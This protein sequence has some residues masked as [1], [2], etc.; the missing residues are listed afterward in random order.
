MVERSFR[1][2][3]SADY[4]SLIRLTL[5]G[6][7]RRAALLRYDRLRERFEA[8]WPQAEA[9]LRR[10]V[11]AE[12]ATRLGAGG[13]LVPFDPAA[14]L[15]VLG[16]QSGETARALGEAI[17][18][19]VGANLQGWGAEAPFEIWDVVA[20]TDDGLSCRDGGP[21]A[22]VESAGA[23]R[24]LVLGDAEFV[25]H[26]IWDVR[27]GSVFAYRCQPAWTLGNGRGADEEDMAPQ[28]R[29]PARLAALDLE[30]LHKGLEKLEEA[31][32]HDAMAALMLPLHFDTLTSIEAWP[33]YAEGLAKAGPLLL[34]RIRLEV[35]HAPPRLDGNALAAALAPAR[36]FHRNISLR[37]GFDYDGF[38]GAMAAG[39]HSVGVD[40]THDQRDEAALI[41]DMEKF[42]VQAG[43]HAIRTHV[44]GLRSISLG[45]AAVCA[46][47]DL[48][49]SQAIGASLEGWPMD[50]YLL[51]PIDL[52]RRLLSQAGRT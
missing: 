33:R 35:V 37:V 4:W 44:L 24:P 27:R 47:F 7:L 12:A 1:Y 41:E 3:G 21:E 10:V 6:D 38:T 23:G 32:D 15:L 36:A 39:F 46:G 34:E 2:Q 20:V 50:D 49:E 18:G 19:T 52:Y 30:T 16:P 11:R 45:V 26:P 14:L 40:L 31:M 13:S 29:T 8:N 17:G 9:A 51:R 25:F 22:P 48:V 43:A 5:S 42:V 28:F